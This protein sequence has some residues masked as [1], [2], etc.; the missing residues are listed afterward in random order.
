MIARAR[1]SE[2]PP[3]M[4]NSWSF[5][6]LLLLTFLQAIIRGNGERS[7]SDRDCKPLKTMDVVSNSGSDCYCYIPSGEVHLKN[8]WSTIQVKIN[9][10]DV[11][12]VVTIPEDRHCQ[13]SENL[14]AFFK[15]LC[16]NIWQSTVSNQI[17]LSVAHY[18]EKTCFRIQPLNQEPYQ[19]NVQQIML[20]H[21][22]FLL[23]I[24]GG[25]LFHFAYSLS[26]STVFYCS[27][28]VALGVLATPVFVILML[29][30]F[31]PK[32]STFWILMSGC[33]FSTLYLYYTLK[34]DLKWLWHTSVHY[35]LGYS[36]IVGLISFAICY[37]HGP[38]NSERSVNLLMWTLQLTGLILI[39]F[40]LAIPQVAYAVIVVMICS[41]ILHHLLRIYNYVGRKAYRF[42][43]PED[44]E[45]RYLTEEEYWEQGEQETRKALEELRSYCK[46]PS[47]PSWVAVVKLQSPQKFAKFVLGLPHVTPEEKQAHKEEYG[48]GG[49]FLEQQLFNPDTEVQPDQQTVLVLVEKNEEEEERLPQNP[50]HFHG[51]DFL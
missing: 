32:L 44:L 35:V 7:F 13:N 14:F 50:L 12:E 37:K 24:A 26:R 4:G 5:L 18:G 8:I 36:L 9:S 39:Y 1:R 16:N 22:L 20:D 47:F 40:G 21:K 15:C 43:K 11:L 33:L 41:K 19:L 2:M 42:F 23:F 27:T 10:S 49:T 25:F 38:L 51:T 6:E 48:I 3:L 46:R 45:V 34:E 29:K 30:R 28:G 31:I 17:I